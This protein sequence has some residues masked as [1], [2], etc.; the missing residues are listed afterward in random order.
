MINTTAAKG[1]IYF[2]PGAPKLLRPPLL[3]LEEP[4]ITVP[5]KAHLCSFPSGL[6]SI[7][8]ILAQRFLG[9][10]VCALPSRVR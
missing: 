3:S 4:E 7:L 9:D 2:S 8:Q 10:E 5:T 6:T 1:P